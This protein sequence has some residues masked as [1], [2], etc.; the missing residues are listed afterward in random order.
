MSHFGRE[1]V[2]K[3]YRE[4]KKRK[5]KGEIEEYEICWDDSARAGQGKQKEPSG[6]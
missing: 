4:L 3:K 1:E 5:E 6:I 2:E